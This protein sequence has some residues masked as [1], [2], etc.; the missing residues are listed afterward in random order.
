ML[1]LARAWTTKVTPPVFAA[2]ASN[3]LRAIMNNSIDAISS[4]DFWTET[5]DFVIIF[6]V[7][8][9]AQHVKSL[10]GLSKASQGMSKVYDYPRERS[11]LWFYGRLVKN[12]VVTIPTPPWA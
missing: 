7:Y 9:G 11:E 4:P 5:G 12:V 8:K 1:S 3:G 6:S 2:E 10:S